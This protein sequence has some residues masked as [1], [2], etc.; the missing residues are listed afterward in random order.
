M[1]ECT[2][3]TGAEAGWEGGGGC[4]LAGEGIKVPADSQLM[5]TLTHVTALA[6]P[7][8][9][10]VHSKACFD[11]EFTEVQGQ[12]LMGRELQRRAMRSW[13]ALLKERWWKG[14]VSMREHEIHKLDHELTRLQARPGYVLQQRRLRCLLHVRFLMPFS[15]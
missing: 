1:H 11:T 4:S 14:Q 5:H 8:G 15:S 7:I 6:K 12:K 2:G 13:H 3:L 9:N 10:Q